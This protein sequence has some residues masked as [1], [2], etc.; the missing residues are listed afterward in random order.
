MVMAERLAL[1]INH[2]QPR[3]IASGRG[4]LGDKFWGEIVVKQVGSEGSQGGGNYR[5]EKQKVEGE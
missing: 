2:E 4:A 1:A 3:L 5:S